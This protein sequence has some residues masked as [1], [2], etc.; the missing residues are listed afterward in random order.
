MTII[1]IITGVTGPIDRGNRAIFTQSFVSSL[2]LDIFSTYYPKAFRNWYSDDWVSSV[3]SSTYV[4]GYAS[5]IFKTSMCV[6]VYVYVCVCVLCA[7][8]YIHSFRVYY[9]GARA[10]ACVLLVF[11]IKTVCVC[12]YVCVCVYV[13]CVCVWMC[14]CMCACM[15]DVCVSVITDIYVRNA[16]PHGTR[17][18]IAFHTQHGAPVIPECLLICMMYDVWCMMYDIW[19]MCVAW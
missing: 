3:Y 5:S 13:W 9:Y 19:C 11:T 4:T 8:V 6:Y 16:N 18:K 2:H 15:C 10:C 17:Y 14:A 1:T 12:A 7:C